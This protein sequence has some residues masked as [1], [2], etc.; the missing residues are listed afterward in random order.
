MLTK[1]NGVPLKR[2][3]GY[4]KYEEESLK[5]LNSLGQGIVDSF[6]VAVQGDSYTGNSVDIQALLFNGLR[7]VLRKRDTAEAFG[8]SMLKDFNIVNLSVLDDDL[9]LDLAVDTVAFA[10]IFTVREGAGHVLGRSGDR[11]SGTGGAGCVDLTNEGGHRGLFA[12]EFALG[13]LGGVGAGNPAE[14][15]GLTQVAGA[16]R[17]TKS[18]RSTGLPTT[19]QA[20]GATFRI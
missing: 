16:H 20:S 6:L 4:R 18:A 13:A 14:D 11:T 19:M 1:K 17:Y 2:N 7:C 3:P 10:F 15:H 9:H 12:L 8:F 5:S